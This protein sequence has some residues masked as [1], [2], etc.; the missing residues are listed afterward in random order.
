MQ[1][2]ELALVLESPLEFT[3]KMGLPA[4]LTV[5]ITILAIL[6]G[7]VTIPATPLASCQDVP[8]QRL[9][10]T[11]QMRLLMMVLVF[12]STNV[13]F[14]EVL[15]RFT[16][17]AVQTFLKATATATATCWMPA[18]CVAEMAASVVDVPTRQRAITTSM[19]L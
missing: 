15:A 9:A 12:F 8:I 3:A 2:L 11:I 7:S 19:R 4:I 17:A 18:A 14:V 5:R 10:T 1:A 13:R 6:L 16:I